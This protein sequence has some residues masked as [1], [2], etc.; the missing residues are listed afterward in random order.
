MTLAIVGLVALALAGSGVGSLVVTRDS[1]RTQ[2]VRQLS[3]EAQSLA[4][5]ARQGVSVARL[6]EARLLLRL[7]D[8][9]LLSLH[10]GGELSG[11]PLPPG[12]GAADLRPQALL[13]GQSVSGIKGPL[14]F[15]AVPTVLLQHRPAVVAGRVVQQTVPKLV[16][17]L[18][19]RRLGSLGPSL[20]YFLLVFGLALAVAALVADRISRRVSRPLVAAVRATERIAAGD[21]GAQVETEAEDYPELAS[22]AESINSMAASLQRSRGLERQFLLSVSHDLRTPLTSIRGYAEAISEGAA[23]PRGAAGVILSES[24]RLERLVQDLLEL[25]KLES[26]SFSLKMRATDGAEVVADT[27]EGFR[28]MVESAGLRLD[29]AV[30]EPGRLWVRADPDR[31]A[32][33]LANLVEN[34]FNFARSRIKVSAGSCD[35]TVT[36][37]VEDDGPGIPAEDAPHVFERLYQSSRAPARQAGSGLGLAIVAELAAAMGAQVSARSPLGPSG[38]TRMVLDLR[39]WD[40]GGRQLLAP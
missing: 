3:A 10:P 30:P 2:A 40:G 6:S 27:V 36:I 26:S 8:V 16:A 12:L 1:A 20:S 23:D 39:A 35:G 32:Q 34:A 4:E 11:G 15:A 18:V 5:R 25:A 7:A 38:G 9:Y 19:A 21:L 29:V 33:V 31:L 37:A 13:A 14:A 24:R 28:P 17:L 22:L